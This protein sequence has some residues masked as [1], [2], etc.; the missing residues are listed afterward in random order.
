MPVSMA[1]RPSLAAA[2]VLSMTACG[3]EED[4]RRELVLVAPAGVVADVTP[5]ERATGC[6]VQ[7]RVY[8]ENED[9]DAIA[10][11]QDADVVAAPAPAGVPP[12]LSLDLVRITLARGLEILLPSRLAAAFDGPAR[13]AAPRSIVWRTR[14]EGENDACGRRWLA[15]ATATG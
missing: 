8:D 10:R 3:G 12:H 15:H 14:R 1:L 9:I 4:L 2:V 7:L 5:F 6:R 13:P 11:R